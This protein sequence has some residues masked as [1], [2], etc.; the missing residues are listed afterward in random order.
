MVSKGFRIKWEPNL[1]AYIFG[2]KYGIEILK[3]DEIDDEYRDKSEVEK[4]RHLIKKHLDFLNINLDEITDKDIIKHSKQYAGAESFPSTISIQT[5]QA[6]I[7]RCAFCY[8]D[9]GI[10]A[11][12]ELS[13]E[14]IFSIIDEFEA[15]GG[16]RI[17]WTGGEALM[18][19]DLWE[20]TEYAQ[21]KGLAQNILTNFA[22][23]DLRDAMTHMKKYF[24]N[25]QVSCNAY[26]DSYNK[27]IRRNLWDRFVENLKKC[28]EYNLPLTLTTVI[29]EENINELE[30][31]AKL[32]VDSGIKE[33]RLGFLTQIGRS[34]TKWPE[35]K[36][37]ID[38]VY[39]V[40]MNIKDKYGHL[41][42]ITSPLDKY[43]EKD[44]IYY[45][46]KEW[47]LSPGGRTMLY[48]QSTGHTYPFPFLVYPEFFLGNAKE[49]SIK[50]MW[51]S[52]KLSPLRN[53]YY[54]N[55]GCKDCHKFCGFWERTFLYS[56]TKDINTQP[57]EHI[58]C[59]KRN[60]EYTGNLVVEELV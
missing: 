28:S 31:I 24:Y 5:T 38:E 47:Y 50:E 48:I 37:V 41:L 8:D 59:V 7:Y 55:T 52:E 57:P 22:I 12:Y 1:N 10:K 49:K 33:W 11:K 9:H 58:G 14:E 51:D 53:V 39:P 4:V 32:C 54:S 29:M 43:D 18:R 36:K 34:T 46:P 21:K 40:I 3:L 27:L 15:N 42:L 6:C 17:E 19:K 30:K 60:S 23:A 16:M 2:N 56:Y 20:I 35:Y 25:V 26:G 45:Y 44:F 13:K